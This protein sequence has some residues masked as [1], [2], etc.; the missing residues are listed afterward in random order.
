LPENVTMLQAFEA[1]NDVLKNGVQGIAEIITNPA[2]NTPA[3]RP[4]LS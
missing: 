2:S 1:A 4:V 3:K